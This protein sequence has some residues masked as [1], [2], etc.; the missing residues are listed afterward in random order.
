[1]FKTETTFAAIR[2][3]TS[4]PASRKRYIH[5]DRGDMNVPYREISLSATRHTDRVE[6]NP[7]LPVY[8]TSGPYTDPDISIDLS[9]GLPALRRAWIEERGDTKRLIGMTSQYAS[10]AR[11]TY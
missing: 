8:D 5:G 3:P 10:S 1:M 4:Y 7:P 2:T 9:R 6:Q 11:T